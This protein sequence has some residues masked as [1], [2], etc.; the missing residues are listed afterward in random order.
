MNR[1]IAIDGPSGAGKSTIAKAAA[2]RLGAHYLDTGAMYRAVCV[3][4]LR[5]NVDLE[6]PQAIADRADDARVDVY[7]DESGLQHTCLNGEDITAILREEA[8][9]M[10]A[11]KV[12]AVRRVRQNQVRRQKELANELFLVCDGRDIGTCVITDAALKIYLT[13]T[14]EE[15]ALRRFREIKDPD[16]SYESVLRD[17]NQRDYNDTHREE[18][19]LVQAPDAVVIDSTHMTAD[20]VVDEVVRLYRLRIGG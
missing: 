19:P 15:R 11:S 6:D 18:S 3:Y 17:I 7:Y 4:M 2:L 13:A 16:C 10:G 9:S 14:A 8:V 12:S 1:S 5:E 20:E